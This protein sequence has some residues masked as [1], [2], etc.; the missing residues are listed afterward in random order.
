MISRIYILHI[1][2]KNFMEY[3]AGNKNLTPLYVKKKI[4]SLKVW[5]KILAQTKSR[6]PSFKSRMV[7][8]LTVF[9]RPDTNTT[10]P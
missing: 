9:A 4:L 3:K 7:V 6:I 1:E 10:K 2:K 5:E 8:L